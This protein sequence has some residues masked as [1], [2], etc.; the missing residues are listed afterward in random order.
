MNVRAHIFVSGRVQGVYFRQNT[1]NQAKRHGVRGWVKNLDDGRVE[2]VFEGD[3]SAVKALV[4]FCHIGPK[5][6][7]VTAVCVDWEPFRAE[8]ETFDIIY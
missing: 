3:E 4:E 7:V 2:A 8:F 6:A 1:K 5:G